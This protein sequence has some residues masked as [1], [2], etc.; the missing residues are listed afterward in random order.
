M[1]LLVEFIL[2]IP[3]AFVVFPLFQS[4]NIPDFL[5]FLF[6]P[7]LISVPSITGNFL[8]V[9][10]SFLCCFS[11]PHLSLPS[12]IDFSLYTFVKRFSRM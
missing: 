2:I 10:L 11:F 12:A 5:F 4:L 6:L 7:N 9:S 3:D 8:E 1:S